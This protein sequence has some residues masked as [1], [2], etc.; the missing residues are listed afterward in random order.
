MSDID[1]VY[2][3]G[4]GFPR[5]RGGPMYYA[6]ERGLERLDAQLRIFSMDTTLPR[7]FWLS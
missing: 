6:T 3:N 4:Y 5:E 7:E 1:A 2:V